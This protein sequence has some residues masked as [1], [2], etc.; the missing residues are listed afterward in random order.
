VDV[1][2]TETELSLARLE[3]DVFRTV[4]FLE[5]LGN[6]K[7]TIRGTIVNNNN[8]PIQIAGRKSA[9]VSKIYRI[10][11]ILSGSSYFSVK[12]F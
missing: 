3:I 1:G 8:F 10:G 6:F 7:G 12:V 5:L 9:R 4:E 11:V 2:S